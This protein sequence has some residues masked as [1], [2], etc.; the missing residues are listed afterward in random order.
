MN[1]REEQNGSISFAN[2]VVATIAGI[3][4]VEVEGVAGMSGGF[5]GGLA[6]LL[7]RKNL[8]KGVKVEVGKEECAVDLYIIVEYGSEIPA[9]TQKIQSNVKKAVETMT[10]LRVVETNIHIQGVRVS[11]ESSEDTKRVH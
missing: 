2:D 7:G 9:M 1:T 6:E 4:T 11:K 5:S 3:A 8:T 10:G